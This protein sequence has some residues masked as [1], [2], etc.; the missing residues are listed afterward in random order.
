MGDRAVAADRRVIELASLKP[1][2]KT[3]TAGS[4]YLLHD[5]LVITAAHTVPTPGTGEVW[6][7]PGGTGPW[8]RCRVLLHRYSDRD[9]PEVQ[10]RRRARDFAVLRVE[11]EAGLSA[12]LPALPPVRWGRLATRPC[13]ARIEATGFP[14]GLRV[15]E[16]RGGPRLATVLRDTAH[17][18]GTVVASD[19]L[20]SR[21]TVHVAHPVPPLP[22]GAAATSEKARTRWDGM[23]GSAVTCD[24]LLV[25]I[26]VRADA[27]GSVEIEETAPLWEDPEARRLLGLKEARPQPA[28]LSGVLHQPAVRPAR[29]PISLLRPEAAAVRFH[30]REDTLRDLTAWRHSAAGDSVLLL[31]GPG[32]QGKTRVGLE[33]VRQA[34]EAGWTAGFLAERADT[35]AL[36]RLST[37]DTPLLLVVDYAETRRSQLHELLDVFGPSGPA[38]GRHPVRILFLARKAGQWWSRLREHARFPRAA[39]VRPL[40]PLEPTAALRATAVRHAMADLGEELATLYPGPSTRQATGAALPPSVTE[41]RYSGA[42]NLQMAVLVTLLQ[43]VD[44]VSVTNGERHEAV[45]LRHEQKVWRR[46]A[47]SHGIG[48]LP[49]FEYRRMV[50]AATLCPA[51]DEQQAL[52]VLGRI[53]PTVLAEEPSTPPPDP[54]PRGRWLRGLYPSD[55][56][57]WGPL[58]PDRLGEYL[59]GG[60]LAEDP[61]LLGRL[62]PATTERQTA[63]A[64]HLLSRAQPHQ[65]HIAEPLRTVVTAHPDPLA[66]RAVDAVVAVENPTPLRQALTAVLEE[67]SGA[68]DRHGSLAQRLYDAV[69]LPTLALDEW[70]ADLAGLLARQPP[71]PTTQDPHEAS[72]EQARRLHRHAVRLVEI[73]RIPAARTAAEKSVALWHTLTMHGRPGTDSGLGLALN[74]LSLVTDHDRSGVEALSLSQDVLRH[75][76]DLAARDPGTYTADLAMAWNNHANRLTDAGRLDEALAG[77]L[78]ARDL[79]R[80]LAHDDPAQ[81]PDVALAEYNLIRIHSALG[82]FGAA[83][84]G[85]RRATDLYHDL[86]ARWP[87]QYRPRVP[88]VLGSLAE[89]L[90]T[91]GLFAEATDAVEECLTESRRLATYDPDRF[92]QDLAERLSDATAVFDDHG[93]EDRARA[94]AEEAVELLRP[95]VERDTTVAPSFANAL[96]A[97][98]HHVPERAIDLRREA[99]TIYERAEASA[100]GVHGS[101]PA[102]ARAA[103]GEA[104]AEGGRYSEGLRAFGE[105]VAVLRPLADR[106]PAAHGPELARVL[107]LQSCALFD[108]GDLDA[109][110]TTATEAY[111]R[112]A[113]AVAEEPGAFL[114]E[115]ARV[116]GNLVFHLQR[117]SRWSEIL[118]RTGQA[119]ALCRLSSAEGR[120]ERPE[121]FDALLELLEYRISAFEQ[122][123]RHGETTDCVRDVV[124]LRRRILHSDPD[125]AGHRL[126]LA[127]E[128]SRLADSLSNAGRP[129]QAADPVREA[130]TLIRS[131]PGG[132]HEED[133]HDSEED[134]DAVSEGA[135][136]VQLAAVLQQAGDT[137]A[138]SAAAEAVRHHEDSSGLPAQGREDG[139][140]QALHLYAAA[141]SAAGHPEAAVEACRHL[142]LLRAKDTVGEAASDQDGGRLD[143]DEALTSLAWA[144]L[145]TGSWP[146]ALGL[147]RGVLRSLTA[148]VSPPP[149][150]TPRNRVALGAALHVLAL[151]LTAAGHHPE[152]LRTARRAFAVR[153]RLAGDAPGTHMAELAE[154]MGVLALTL[155]ATGRTTEAT[156][157]IRR[158]VALLT[159][160][161]TTEPAAHRNDLRRLLRHQAHIEGETPSPGT[162]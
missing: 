96:I 38:H 135:L 6:I 37:L 89:L 34:E 81:L 10:E 35:R 106:L 134:D 8:L 128:L 120:P 111:D 105:S 80:D 42:L 53:R 72:V 17:I 60:V 133:E 74:T 77:A 131:V 11:D 44:P 33:A 145:E 110:L 43:A 143:L 27:V 23:S 119:L 59:L 112:F 79:Y 69:P 28:E 160:L 162:A 115:F 26:V 54:V 95:L 87:D 36:P 100:P 41:D 55:D 39:A 4:G 118:T 159:R 146:R 70:V 67:I 152:A 48:D 68:M 50:A 138:L 147:A 29:T 113:A 107:D 155:H 31:T 71:G 56:G 114:D 86:A 121:R 82:R 51:D 40:P 153:R 104:L 109:A 108:A 117:R 12:A 78:T 18:I 122:L 126:S 156:T 91:A 15:Y 75:Y 58:Q 32:G 139:Y 9:A 103:L 149:D 124:A 102:V 14:A 64:F 148:P 13:S 116:T 137:E 129:S 49:L 132:V 22:D 3:H 99:V 7:R 150:T 157:M 85:A 24:G 101:A 94:A 16:D 93:D 30:G 161:A 25:G 52:A 62:L 125:D 61:E 20:G 136:L 98:S 151:A 5:R 73:G 123:G 130:L 141:Q 140:G 46:T 83:M 66:L 154:T 142:V 47:G 88:E 90:R 76:R 65:P 144:L 19:A 63:A 45:L 57:Y 21:H 84:A 97:L 2:A 127:G 92:E 1:G 158:A